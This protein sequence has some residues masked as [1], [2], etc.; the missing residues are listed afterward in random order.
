MHGY[1]QEFVRVVVGFC[2]DDIR[3]LQEPVGELLDPCSYVF[4]HSNHPGRLVSKHFACCDLCDHLGDF[5]QVLAGL[6][7]E[8]IRDNVEDLG[9]AVNRVRVRSRLYVSTHI[10]AGLR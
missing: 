1:I 5:R 6:S 2:V 4:F 7:G 3:D 10:I 9:R 8:G